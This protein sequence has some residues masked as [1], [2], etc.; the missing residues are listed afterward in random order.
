M[1][2]PY[3]VRKVHLLRQGAAIL[4]QKSPCADEGV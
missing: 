4:M 2:R 3:E 1:K